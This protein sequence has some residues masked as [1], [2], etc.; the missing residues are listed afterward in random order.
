[1]ALIVLQPPKLLIKR[2]FLFFAVTTSFNGVVASLFNMRGLP[3]FAGI[4]P[5][6]IH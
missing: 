3:R 2:G 6:V 5:L 1:M 4:D